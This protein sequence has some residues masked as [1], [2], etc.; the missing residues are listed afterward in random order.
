MSEEEDGTTFSKLR[1]DGDDSEGD[2]NDV[3]TISL[4][5]RKI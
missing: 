5:K 2:R 4:P 1:L 3:E